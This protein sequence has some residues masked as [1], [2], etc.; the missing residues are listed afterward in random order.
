M[1][2]VRLCYY[3]CQT[4]LRVRRDASATASRMP[5]GIAVLVMGFPRGALIL[6]KLSGFLCNAAA[7]N[8]D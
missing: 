6:S 1:G 2:N 8:G 5:L 3:Q 7:A 4:Y